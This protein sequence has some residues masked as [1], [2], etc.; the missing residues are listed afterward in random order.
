MAILIGALMAAGLGAFA[1]MT[2]L[3][4]SRA[5]YPTALMAIASYY[6][7]FAVLGGAWAALPVELLQFA[8]FGLAAVIGFRKDLRVAAVAL[9][10]HGALDLVHPGLVRNPGVPAW[11]PPFCLGFDLV[12]AIVLALVIQARSGRANGGEARASG[13]PLETPR[14]HPM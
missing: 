13:H 3:D 9:I 7:L 14:G 6:V 4:R 1:A 8:V 5:F 10:A 2:G 11:W 12:F